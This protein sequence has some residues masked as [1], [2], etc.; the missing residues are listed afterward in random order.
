M[1]SSCVWTFLCIAV[2]GPPVGFVG[3]KVPCTLWIRTYVS[4]KWYCA[5]SILYFVICFISYLMSHIAKQW[6]IGGTTISQSET[7]DGNPFQLTW[8]SPGIFLGE[9]GCCWVNNKTRNGPLTRCVKLRVVHALGMPRRFPRHRRLA[10]PTCIT[11]RSSRTCRDARRDRYL[12]ISFQ[13]GGEENVLDIPGA[14]AT[15]TFTYMVRDPFPV[16][17]LA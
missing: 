4:A 14:R 10:I 15:R 5:I 8:F 2:V 11:A 13:V 6:F 1:T 17:Q 16:L 12:L 9:T 3:F 7:V